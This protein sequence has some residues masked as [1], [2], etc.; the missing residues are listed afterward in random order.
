MR[1]LY[2]L[3]CLFICFGVSETAYPAELLIRLVDNTS[4][5]TQAE[6]KSA[7]GKTGDV[8]A[9]RHNGAGWGKKEGPPKYAVI[10]IPDL[11][12][13]QAKKYLEPEIDYTD[14]ENPIT[15]T[16]RKYRLVF[17]ELSTGMKNK[18]KEGTEVS[19]QW[20]QIKGKVEN[21]VTL[22]REQ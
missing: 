17:S 18:L 13:A 16:Y 11:T 4:Q 12:V 15:L 9:I 14:P 10:K 2:F 5:E 19:V 3:F 6:Q 20:T 8:I 7:L 21:K 1:K 22:E